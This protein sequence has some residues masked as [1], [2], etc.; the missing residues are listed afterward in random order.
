MRSLLTAR[1]L[2]R[3]P[4][5]LLPAPVRIPLTPYRFIEFHK[6]EGPGEV[7]AG[8]WQPLSFLGGSIEA[9]AR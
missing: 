3:Q 8:A 7:V 2:K 6:V 5:V 9:T 4:F 1:R